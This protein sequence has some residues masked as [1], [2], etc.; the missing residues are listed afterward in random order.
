MKILYISYDGML[1]PL[2]QSQV[3]AYQE[4]LS[5]DFTI[6]LVSFEKKEDLRD[7]ASLQAMKMKMH[8]AG[9][10]WIPLVY[11]KKLSVLSTSIDIAR[12]IL[13]GWR[14]IASH[15]I[16]VIHAR[17]YVPGVMAVI[18][19][20]FLRKKFLFDM[21]GLW[22]DERVDG[23]LWKK[24]SY[25]YYIAK[26]F[27]KILLLHAD[28][29]ISLTHAGIREIEKFPYLRQHAVKFT[30]IP[31]CV[32]LD[33]F[34][35][36]DDQNDRFTLGYVGS[37]GV[38]YEFDAVLEAFQFLASI[39]LNAKLL[40]INRNEHAFLKEKI[41]A[42]GFQQS[43][44]E[45]ISTHY[46]QVPQMMSRMNAG[47]F[48][49]KPLFSKQASAPTKLG[50]FLACGIPCLA[51]QGVGDMAAV[52]EESNVGIAVSDFSFHSLK[53]G[54]EQLITLSEDSNIALRCRAAAIK[55]F[56]LEAGVKSYSDV[57]E[58]LREST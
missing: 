46:A 32:D 23:G 5:S 3:V 33:K 27:E 4:Q 30:V 6:F 49:I 51:N 26:W 21:R 2:G 20:I 28:H 54:V 45:I 52:L 13:T 8:K 17:S 43:Q 18:L 42:A 50:E 11:H 47:I 56:S 38:W 35:Y 31:T 15:K 48:F 37:V 41:T 58:S 10:T 44:Y 14:L 22:P 25:L 53:V 16:D 9:I 1:E 19:K 34:Y 7:K 57:Y 24:N 29:V 12:G 39:Q 55:N 36:S 40:I